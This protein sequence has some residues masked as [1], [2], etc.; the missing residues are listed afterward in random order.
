MLKNIRGRKKKNKL[1]ILFFSQ[2]F[3]PENFR[4]N[5][6][7]KFF[8]KKK[9]ALS[10]LTT[11]PSYPDKKIFQ[12]FKDKIFVSKKIELKRFRSFPRSGTNLSILLNYLTFILNSLY[13]IC[14]YLTFKKNDVIFIFCPSPILSA[15]P[16]I[17]INKLFNKK[18]VIWVL[19]LWPDT[20]IDLKIVK[21][22]FL[23]FILKKIVNYIYNN[24]NLILAQSQK[25][26][27]IIE[28]RTST[29]CIFFPSWPEE[30]A[31]KGLSK[32]NIFEKKNKKFLYIIFTGN[33]GEAQSFDT[34]IKAV[35]IL[36]KK[37]AIKW[38][39]VGEGRWKE[40]FSNLINK[41]KLNDHI[42]LFKSVDVSQISSILDYSDALYLSLKNNPTFN[43]TIPGKL[44]TYMASG[45]PIIGSISG[46]ANKIINLSNCGFASEAEDYKKLVKIVERFIRLNQDQRKKLGLNGKKYVLQNFSKKKIINNLI[47]NIINL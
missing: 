40:K 9:I 31:K 38:I 1:K 37:F 2:Y 43:K 20:I 41:N 13:T 18:I 3:W 6:L 46:E 21:N 17:L 10:V 4:I 5:E 44:Q 7:V 24:S 12:N 34:L 30:D 16:V 23:I 39:I 8:Y 15:L 26:K 33:I 14:K 36:K 27:K 35:K 29:K 45:K 11:F 28:K 32:I 47:K 22:K 42:K 19:D 25:I